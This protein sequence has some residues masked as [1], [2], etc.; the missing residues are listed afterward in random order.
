[1]SETKKSN[2]SEKKNIEEKLDNSSSEVSDLSC[3]KNISIKNVENDVETNLLNTPK[4]NTIL[5]K[6]EDVAK[7]KKKKKTQSPKTRLFVS[8]E[9][10]GRLCEKKRG[11]VCHSCSLTEIVDIGD[12][13]RVHKEGCVCYWCN[14]C[15][16]ERE[17]RT[18]ICQTNKV[19][20]NC[21]HLKLVE[22][23]EE[24][25]NLFE[26]PFDLDKLKN[27]IL[28]MTNLR[29]DVLEKCFIYLDKQDFDTVFWGYV[30]LSSTF[31]KTIGKELELS[32]FLRSNI[33]K[34]LDTQKTCYMLM[35]KRCSDMLSTYWNSEI[36]HPNID[37]NLEQ[38][39]IYL[40]ILCRNSLFDKKKITFDWNSAHIEALFEKWA[41]W[42]KHIASDDTVK[43]LYEKIELKLFNKK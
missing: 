1:M 33:D 16:L 8:G 37:K 6:L 25:L 35:Q 4:N 40:T 32:K 43:N 14:L 9:R 41:G 19:L 39:S 15:K 5:S 31:K 13:I 26:K 17:R 29:D 3:K 2:F 18:Q 7:S 21:D 36:K 12:E 34:K 42:K 23:N 10:I 38:I 24:F 28:Q 22:D 27:I 30:K 11:P 20:V